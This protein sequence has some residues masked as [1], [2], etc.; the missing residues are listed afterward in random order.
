MAGSGDETASGEG[1]RHHL[2]TSRAD[3]EQVIELLKVAFVQ[4]RL[5]RDEFGRRVGRTL[6][7]R[8]YGDLP[9][10]TAGLAPARRAGEPAREPAQKRKAAEPLSWATVAV[11]GLLAGLPLVP[12]GSP[13]APVVLLVFCLSCTAVATGWL[14]LLHSWVDERA[15]R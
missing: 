4:G 11:A 2:R 14:V 12:D 10:L 3:R 8:T 1:G 9:A 6:A 5:D 13:F 7:S 15:G